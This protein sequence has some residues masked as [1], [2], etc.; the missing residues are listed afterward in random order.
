MV[1]CYLLFFGIAVSQTHTFNNSKYGNL[2]F[3]EHPPNSKPN[4]NVSEL[5]VSINSNDYIFLLYI[6]SNIECVIHLHNC[7]II[8][9]HVLAPC[10]CLYRRKCHLDYCC[11]DTTAI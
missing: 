9:L 7:L 4:K 6:V 10:F 2:N 11:L 3:I 5:I 1:G 8:L